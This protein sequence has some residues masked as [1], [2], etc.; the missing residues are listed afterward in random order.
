[1][2]CE[3]VFVCV[4]V[5]VYL[6]SWVDG[7]AASCWVHAGQ[8]LN[9]V[10]FLQQQL[11]TVIPVSTHTHTHTHTD[12]KTY[13]STTLHAHL[14]CLTHIHLPDIFTDMDASAPT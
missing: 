11:S 10:Y 5:C 14:L 8:L 13:Y 4:G 6:Q 7:D 12:Q 9:V 2:C 1:M 3:D